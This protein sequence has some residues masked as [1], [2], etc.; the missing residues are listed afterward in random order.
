M[1]VSMIGPKFYAWDRNG[2]PLAFGKVYTYQARTNSPKPTYQSEDQKVENTNPVILNGE[3]YAN[4]Y[5][6]GSYKIVL[7]DDKDNEI[8]SADP[9]SEA[10]AGNGLTYVL[11]AYYLTS[12]SFKVLGDHLS[13]MV[14][15]A[16]VE[17]GFITN[18]SKQSTVITSA[19]DGTFTTVEI[20]DSIIT[21]DINTAS[22]P[23]GMS[24]IA[25]F[26]EISQEQ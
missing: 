19:F 22:L 5:L 12:S 16:R 21:T 7:K 18:A 13:V 8:W 10:S 17:I 24:A 23:T 20:E 9:V 26:N 4:I 1:A 11:T 6:S 25:D 3:G 14:E 15:G 2:K